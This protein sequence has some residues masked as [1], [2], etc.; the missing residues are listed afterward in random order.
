MR[1]EAKTFVFL[2]LCLFLTGCGGYSSTPT[3][4]VVSAPAIT[5]QPSQQTV[6]LGQTA[7]FSV[8]ASG[9]APLAYQWQKGNTAISGATSSNYTT[10]PTTLADNAAQFQVVVSNSAGS[11]TSHPATLV[12]NAATT[13]VDVLTYHNDKGRTGQNL[14]ETELTPSSVNSAT[15]GKLGSY[16]LDGRV[17]TQPLYA[18]QV[19][20]PGKGTPNLLIVPTEHDS[21]Y[22][23]DADTGATI[24]KTSMLKSG[25]Q[26]SDPRGCSQ[27]SPE[28]GVTATPVIDRGRG[29]NGIVYVV[30]MS[31]DG[32]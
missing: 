11:V 19:A 20:V 3:K 16:T 21:V 31:K 17:D 4:S 24:W 32:S 28:I 1:F 23:L 12:V 26:T 14:N 18:S 30:A 29:P 25:E 2:P 15:F 13:S 6:T 22:A 27:V 5:T 7:T 9:T 8:T 10:P